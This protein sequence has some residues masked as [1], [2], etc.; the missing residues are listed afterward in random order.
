M[1]DIIHPPPKEF[2]NEEKRDGFVVSTKMKSVWAVE[3]DLAQELLRVCE[4]YNL[5]IF[6]DFG[7]L[8]GTI[9]H[10]GF[11]PW[12]DDMD[13]IML[14]EDYE[15]LCLIATREFKHPYFFQYSNT[16]EDFVNGHAKLR[17]SL[18]TGIVKNELGRNLGYNQ[19]IFIDIF[20]LDNVSDNGMI[21]FIQMHLVRFLNTLMLAFAYFSTRYFE[22][23]SVFRIPKKIIHSVASK[24][25]KQ[26]QFI[27]YKLMMFFCLMFS[28]KTTKYVAGLSFRIKPTKQLRKDYDDTVMADYEYLKMPIVKEYDRVLTQWF[29]NWRVPQMSGNDHGEVLFD[30]DRPYTDYLP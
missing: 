6:A 17:N 5:K 10:K 30:V 27:S 3:L 15:K 13:F 20:P 2:F 7:T 24:P 21:R 29:G 9:R 1:V 8:L 16:G 25:F 4:K 18:T 14:R 22:S 11:I 23:Q 12:D 19:G 26:F 28:A